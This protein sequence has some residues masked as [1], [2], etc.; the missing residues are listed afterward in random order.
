[1]TTFRIPMGFVPMQAL[2]RLGKPLYKLAQGMEKG[3]PNLK[4]D[5]V[6][7]E[8][9]YVARDYIAMSIVASGILFVFLFIFCF[10]MTKLGLSI[11]MGFIISFFM[12]LIMFFQKL[13]YP[14]MYANGRVKSIERNLL[15]ALQNMLIQLNAGV[16][17]FNIFVSIAQG[18]YGGVSLEFEKAVREMNAG[19]SQVNTLNDLASRNPSQYFRRAVWQLTNGIKTGADLASVIQDTI[20][21]LSEYQLIQIE[22]YGGQLKPLAMFYLLIAVIMPSLGTTFV[23]LLSSFVA[24]SDFAIKLI[25]WGLLTVTVFFQLV[26]IGII[27]SRRPNLLE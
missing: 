26:F 17:L 11:F 14:K 12:T 4:I 20:N 10:F 23:I 15:P 27:K 25:F 7:A 8:V 2:Q 9:N 1:M 18:G 13:A 22:K 3:L 5:L 21:S 24:L 16:P 6:R 19:R